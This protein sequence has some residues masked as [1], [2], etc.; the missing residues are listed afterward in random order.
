MTGVE[1][2]PPSSGDGIDIAPFRGAHAVVVLPTLNEEEGLARTLSD[3]PIARFDDR[4]QKVRVLV[5]DGGS[6]DGTLEVARAAGVPVLKQSSRGKGGA[7]LEAVAWVHRLG[8]PFVVALDADARYPPDRILPALDLLRGGTDLVIG[9][10]RPVWGPPSD[11]KDLI[12]RVGNVALSYTASFL[13]RRSILDLCSG[14]WGVSTE[15]FMQLGL[16]HSSFAIEAELV[17]KSVRRGYT[18]HQIP[19]DYRERVGQPKLRAVRDGSQIL[20]T[21]LRHARSARSSLP[22]R[23]PAPVTLAR[24]LP[25]LA[26]PMGSYGARVEFRRPAGQEGRQLVRYLLPDPP[27]TRI[28]DAGY[29]SAAGPSFESA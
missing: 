26:P 25:S 20:R 6:T 24:S 2:T 13:S 17:L 10:R 27:G 19:V 28:H 7:M 29:A 15:R 1:V 4:G 12:H 11:F 18:V 9:V 3:L 16:T 23:Y 22:G 8:I 21:V 14:F 5:V